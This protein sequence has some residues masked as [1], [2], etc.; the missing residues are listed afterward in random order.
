[1]AK[2]IKSLH[3]EIINCIRNCD[4]DEIKPVDIQ[5]CLSFCHPQFAFTDAK[6]PSLLTPV[7]WWTVLAFFDPRAGNVYFLKKY[8]EIVKCMVWEFE[9]T[10]VRIGGLFC[11]LTPRKENWYN[12]ACVDIYS[13]LND[14]DQKDSFF[15]LGACKT[16]FLKSC[17]ENMMYQLPIHHNV[18]NSRKNQTHRTTNFMIRVA[19]YAR[20]MKM[21]FLCST[22]DTIF[23]ISSD[24]QLKNL[25]VTMDPGQRYWIL[26]DSQPHTIL[27]CVL[28]SD[29]G[30]RILFF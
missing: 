1:M 26:Y 23:F 25:P 29:H 30:S 2:Q 5:C 21:K 16:H 18:S 8:R 27:L 9:S 6:Y 4:S 11:S 7:V 17:P 19:D 10:R 24:V 12:T 3:S 13:I 20:L 15:D 22:R 14:L 28:F